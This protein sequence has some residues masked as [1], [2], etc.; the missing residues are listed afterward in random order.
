MF[1]PGGDFGPLDYPTVIDGIPIPRGMT[2]EQINDWVKKEKEAEERAEKRAREEEELMEA[3]RTWQ[4]KLI[5]QLDYIHERIVSQTGPENILKLAQA[6]MIV[7]KI[8]ER[9]FD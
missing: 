2:Q 4:K 9:R 3:D 7:T 5:T 1:G 8:K 6:E